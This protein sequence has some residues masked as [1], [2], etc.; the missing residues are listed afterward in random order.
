MMRSVLRARGPPDY[1]SRVLMDF[2]AGLHLGDFTMDLQYTTL[3]NPNKNTLTPADNTDK[4]N[5]ASGMQVQLTYRPI[6]EILLA[7]RYERLTNDPGLISALNEDSWGVAL[8][9]RFHPMLE[10]RTEY[11]STNY[12]LVSEETWKSNRFS[13]GAVFTF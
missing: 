4:E 3:D 6:E 1:G 2:L 11:I 9:Y 12:H 7:A 10:A 5:P 8:H 13:I